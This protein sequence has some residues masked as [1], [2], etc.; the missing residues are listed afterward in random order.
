[1]PKI[2][3][4]LTKGAA[5]DVLVDGEACGGGVAGQALIS[6]ATT[7]KWTT[8]VLTSILRIDDPTATDEFQI[9]KLG[10][11]AGRI[12]RVAYKTD[13]GTWD[14]NVRIRD[15]SKPDDATGQTSLF[16]ADKQATSTWAIV[17][18]GFSDFTLDAR[19][20]LVIDSS[21]MS[22]ATRLYLSI[23]VEMD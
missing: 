14:F 6:D 1:M 10:P 12:T 19:Q 7:G 11:R 8:L 20:W 18:S 3:G 4:E 16:A 21:A 9:F 2:V 5:F 23:E 15:D 22:G 17:T 13:A